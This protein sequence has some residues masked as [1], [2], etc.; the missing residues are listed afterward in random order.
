MPA[1][2]PVNSIK[3]TIKQ[4]A[5]TCL[6]PITLHAEAGTER[7][8]FRIAFNKLT[9]WTLAGRSVLPEQEMLFD[10]DRLA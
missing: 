9:H 3:Q 10:Y 8:L 2:T 4:L 7:S 6:V 1:P 5:A